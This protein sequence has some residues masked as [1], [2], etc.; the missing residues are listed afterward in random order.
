MNIDFP[1]VNFP[2]GFSNIFSFGI[3]VSQVVEAFIKHVRMWELTLLKTLSLHDVFCLLYTFSISTLVFLV[4]CFM[5]SGSPKFSRYSL[6]GW[7]CSLR[8]LG[9]SSMK[10]LMTWFYGAMVLMYMHG[11]NRTLFRKLNEN[12]TLSLSRS[13]NFPQVL[14]VHELPR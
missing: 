10:V 12:S 2:H 3:Y 11:T 5:N 8:Y 14:I 13:I 7:L 4:V 1:L 9:A 6:H